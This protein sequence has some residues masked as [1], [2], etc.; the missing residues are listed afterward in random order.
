M[1]VPSI[2]GTAF[3]S[4]QE[5]VNRLVAEGALSRQL[6]E[7]RCEPGDLAILDGKI[8]PSAWYPIDAYVRLV[9]LLIEKQAPGN[10]EG[11]LHER[12][13]RA[14]E[15]L[16]AA[17]IYPQLEA[18]S[19]R[20]G[21]RVG[22]FVTTLS[23]AIYNFTRWRY[24]VAESGDAFDIFVED[25]AGFPNVARFTAQGFIEAAARRISGERVRVTS[26]RATPDRIVFHAAYPERA[27]AT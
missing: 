27:R 8:N 21:M 6:V 26:E 7:L 2:K 3:Q 13:V 5:D 25:A 17:G 22:R 1:S 10:P 24:D 20:L 14:A 16:A 4:A 12:G 19:E 18:S 23:S 9:E 15:R 11:Y